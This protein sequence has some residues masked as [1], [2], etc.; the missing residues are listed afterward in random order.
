MNFLFR[1][2]NKPAFH[3]AIVQD[4]GAIAI[5]AALLLVVLMGFGALTMD[6]G[7]WYHQKRQLQ[8]AAD[9]GAMGGAI[10]K[11]KGLPVSTYATYDLTLNQCTG[12][13]KC[14]IVGIHNPPTSGPNTGDN[15]AVEVILSKP[16]NIFL[17]GITMATAPT[18]H[19]RSVATQ[20]PVVYCN[21][22]LQGTGQGLTMQGNPTINSPS[23][24]FYVDSS[25]SNAVNLGGNPSINVSALTVVGNTNLSGASSITGNVT[26]GAPVLAD[27]YSSLSAPAPTSLNT[28]TQT[29]FNLGSNKA[30]TIGPGTYCGGI[31]T[32]GNLTMTPGTY[33]LVG[34][35]GKTGSAGN[36][37]VSGG[38][39]TGTGGVTIVLTT[40]TATSNTF[41]AVSIGANSSVNLIAPTTGTYAGILF[42]GDRNSSSILNESFGG[43][44]TMNLQGAIYFPKGNLSFNGNAGGTGNPCTQI[45]VNSLTMKGTSSFQNGCVIPGAGGGKLKFIE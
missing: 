1:W 12:S 7:V 30:Q 11:S 23:C 36:F 16:A 42:Y 33:Y 9:A 20:N 40:N 38:T 4:K 22:S 41:G 3:K 24:G 17:S 28:C 15:N 45:V 2:L 19:A 35:S 6:V 39:V 29:N 26:T 13:A 10:A 21:I 25:S 44:G 43:G 8:L 5:M 27:P 14:T 34:S 32:K 18:L 37:T 31:T